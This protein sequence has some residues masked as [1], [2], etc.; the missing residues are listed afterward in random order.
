MIAV[1]DLLLPDQH[2]VLIGA[3]GS[4][5]STVGRL[6]AART[7]RRFL[8]NDDTLTA[9]LRVTAASVADRDGLDVLHQL[10]ADLLLDNLSTFL[11]AVVAGAASVVDD[12]RVREALAD[13]HTVVWLEGDPAALARRAGGAAHRPHADDAAA[14]RGLAER[15]ARRFA[16]TADLIVDVTTATPATIIDHIVAG[17]G[18]RTPVRRQRNLLPPVARLTSRDFGLGRRQ[19]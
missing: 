6:L 10:E 18:T 11:P 12:R 16:S 17:L 3:M 19:G 7:G 14:L 2:V 13:N 5:K 9:R 1:D 8:D 15:R 4:G